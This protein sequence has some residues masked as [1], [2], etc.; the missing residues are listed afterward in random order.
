MELLLLLWA[1]LVGL[2]CGLCVASGERH[3]VFWNS[4]NPKF[5]WDSYAVE[6][7]LNDYL[8]IICPHYEDSSVA[9]HSMERYT[10]YLVEQEEYETCK[11]RSKEQ[12]RW[13][14]NKPDAL[15]G[16]ERFS[17]K[18]QRYTPFTL[19]KEFREGHE[20]YY[21]SK[22][23][24]HHGESCLKLKVVVV[25]KNGR[26]PPSRSPTLKGR[27]QSG[28]SMGES[29]FCRGVEV[30]QRGAAQSAICK[31]PIDKRPLWTFVSSFL[32]PGNCSSE[33]QGRG[34]SYQLSAPLANKISQ[35][36]LGGTVT[37]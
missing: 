16:P 17:E 21:I 13:E 19:G 6:V 26:M 4:T 33:F 35:N 15:H 2:W 23:I 18:F 30:P 11:P 7:R 22:P 5:Q 8:D 3:T 10:L 9:P 32:L 27:H 25:G 28:R 24:H 1:P 20:Y 34:V 31:G 14:C 12:I 37:F 29:L 36:T